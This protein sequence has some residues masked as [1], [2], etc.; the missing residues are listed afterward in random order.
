MMVI[1]NL[2]F[3]FEPR[4]FSKNL[5]IRP[6]EEDVNATRIDLEDLLKGMGISP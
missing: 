5:L 6:D 3:E 4:T 1:Y 2:V